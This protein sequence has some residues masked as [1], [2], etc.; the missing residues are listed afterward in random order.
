VNF[1]RKIIK[2]AAIL[3]EIM[4]RDKIYLVRISA[5]YLVQLDY[6][7]KFAARKSRLEL[8]A[9]VKTSCYCEFL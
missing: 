6:F 7:F 4:N 1:S 3:L 8:V 2:S 5:I 9:I